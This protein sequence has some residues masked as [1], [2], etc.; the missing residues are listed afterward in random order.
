MSDALNSI[1]SQAKA[2]GLKI[3][4]H[5]REIVVI[6][7]PDAQ[8]ESDNPGSHQP[9]SL[10]DRAERREGGDGQIQGP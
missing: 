6:G 4:W 10:G 1:V 2:A 9:V 7:V 3:R 5:G 8:E